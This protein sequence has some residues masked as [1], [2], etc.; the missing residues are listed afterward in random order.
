MSATCLSLCRL[1]H[2]PWWDFYDF[3]LLVVLKAK[4]RQPLHYLILVMILVKHFMRELG[5]FSL[6]LFISLVRWSFSSP[7]GVPDDFIFMS[8]AIGSPHQ[9]LQHERD[10]AIWSKRLVFCSK[11]LDGGKEWPGFCVNIIACLI[12]FSI[13]IF[14][15]MVWAKTT[16]EELLPNHYFGFSKQKIKYVIRQLKRKKEILFV[17]IFELIVD[18]QNG[19]WKKKE[20]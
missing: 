5:F 8:Y 14:K 12:W 17:L 3:T 4:Q 7:F 13:W 2:Q 11:Q 20:K 6:L 19:C 9:S 10:C 1:L 16:G 15:T 18:T